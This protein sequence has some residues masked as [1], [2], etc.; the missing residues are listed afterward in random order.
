MQN[1]SLPSILRRC[2]TQLSCLLPL[3]LGLATLANAAPY[4]LVHDP[5]ASRIAV[6]DDA[7]LLEA[8]SIAQPCDLLDMIVHPATQ[9]LY[10]LESCAGGPSR[11]K[12]VDTFNGS[13]QIVASGLGFGGFLFLFEGDVFHVPGS[14]TPAGGFPGIMNMSSIT[15]LGWRAYQGDALQIVNRPVSVDRGA[16]VDVLIPAVGSAGITLMQ[17][18]YGAPDVAVSDLAGLASPGHTFDPPQLH[19]NALFLVGESGNGITHS[20]LRV[21]VASG[22]PMTLAEM[23]FWAREPIRGLAL[24]RANDRAFVLLTLGNVGSTEIVE[25]DISGPG[26]SVVGA[27]IV[28]G[29]TPTRAAWV[30]GRLYYTSLGSAQLVSF[31]PATKA[32]RSFP[33]AP[34]PAYAGGRIASVTDIGCFDP[35]DTD[36]DGFPDAIDLCPDVASGSNTDSDGDG[37]GDA[38]DVCRLV[39]DPGQDDRDGDGVGDAC[40]NCPVEPNGNQRDSDGDGMGNACDDDDDNDGILDPY[41]NCPTAPNPNQDDVDGDGVGNACDNCP[42]VR[43][44]LQG[45]APGVRVGFCVDERILYDARLAGLDRVVEKFDGGRPWEQFGHCPERC[46]EDVLAEVL[47]GTKLAESHLDA[48]LEDGELTTEGVRAFLELFED[49]D[50]EMVDA[51]MERVIHGKPAEQGK[52]AKPPPFFWK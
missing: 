46:P 25:V 36:C 35:S 19:G 42:F 29:G 24:D 6:V 7:T 16:V 1:L 23:P 13:E 49:A 43:N 8:A 11:V 44:P 3:V 47:M 52:G 51:Y 45:P 18:S 50:R 27:D 21:D 32:V 30:A 2:A 9:D 34:A 12:A 48:C 5:G 15:G 39:A 20:L 4:V 33:L 38:C 17:E 22:P 26:L 28:P 10:V 14:T 41:D 40:D 37:V 31:D